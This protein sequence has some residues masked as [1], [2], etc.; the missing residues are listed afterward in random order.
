LAENNIRALDATDTT[1]VI[2]VLQDWINS[3]GILDGHLWLEYVE[4]ADGLGY[5]IKADGGLITEEDICGDFTAELPFIIYYTT[6]I[7]PDGAGAVYKPLNDLSAWF[8]AN[9]PAGLEIGERR[10]SRQLLTLAAPKDL[11]GKDELGNTTFFAVY[12]I[13]YDEEAL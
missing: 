5:C 7:V 1:Q 3:L 10:S 4:D 2:A 12:Q 6:N 13:I 9:G 11:E 8:K